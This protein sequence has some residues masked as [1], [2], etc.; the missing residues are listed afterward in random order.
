M[1]VPAP[2]PASSRSQS[3]GLW[4]LGRSHFP[5]QVPL[6]RS[7]PRASPTS[8]GNTGRARGPGGR[9]GTSGHSGSRTAA[10]S[11]G[12]RRAGIKPIV[13]K[14]GV[15]TGLQ[16]HCAPGQTH[17]PKPELLSRLQHEIVLHRVMDCPE[18]PPSWDVPQ[19]RAAAPGSVR[20]RVLQRGPAEPTKP[21]GPDPASC[22]KYLCADPAD[23]RAAPGL[24]GR[25]ASRSLPRP[26][27]SVSGDQRTQLPNCL[28]FLHPKS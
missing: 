13:G 8:P 15:R 1:P 9:P 27:A 23:A 7:T 28:F 3:D 21:Y 17:V 4:R 12:R 14:R 5:R 26:D 22:R 11:Q 6:G 19:P 2:S 20:V 18:V 25:G 16:G 24:R 10:C